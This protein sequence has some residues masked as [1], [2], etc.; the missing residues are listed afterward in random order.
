M[1]EKGRG[2]P[3]ANGYHLDR[4]GATGEGLKGLEGVVCPT[5]R[6]LTNGGEE[7][8]EEEGDGL[9]APPDSAVVEGS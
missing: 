8:E 5:Q 2:R 9:K 7:E 1:A 4:V 3:R 6:E